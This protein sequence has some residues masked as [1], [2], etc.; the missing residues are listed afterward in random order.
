MFLAPQKQNGKREN[1]KWMKFDQTE[2]QVFRW[3]SKTKVSMNFMFN[4]SKP[5]FLERTQPMFRCFVV[6]LERNSGHQK[7]SCFFAP[8]REVPIEL[9]KK[10]QPWKC[11]STFPKKIFGG[12]RT[13]KF[14]IRG[15]RC[16]W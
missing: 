10:F 8:L 5:K 6:S 7:N 9:R 13:T 4:L 16:E 2:S 14:S 12:Q 15:R 1:Q 11:P 3:E